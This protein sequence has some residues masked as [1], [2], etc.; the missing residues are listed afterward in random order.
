MFG[1]PASCRTEGSSG[2]GCETHLI[3]LVIETHGP[4]LV[5]HNHAPHSLVGDKNIR[6][7]S[8]NTKLHSQSPELKRCIGQFIRRVRFQQEFCRPT[9]PCGRESRQRHIHAQAIPEC[10]AQCL[11]RGGP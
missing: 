3:R 11:R 8:E 4:R 10:L 5:E 9:D 1:G 2:F 7:A 6:S